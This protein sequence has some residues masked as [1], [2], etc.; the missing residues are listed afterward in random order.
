MRKRIDI[1]PLVL[2]ASLFSCRESQSVDG[3]GNDLTIGSYSLEYVKS[4]GFTG[5]IHVRM[6]V[7]ST[8]DVVL[9][10]ASPTIAGALTASEQSRLATLGSEIWSQPDTLRGGCIDDFHFLIQWTD[11]RGT[12]TISADGCSLTLNNGTDHAAILGLVQILDSIASRVFQEG[13]TWRGMEAFFS[14][15][16]SSYALG[17]PITLKYALTNPTARVRSIFFPHAEQYWFTVSKDN[18]PSFYYTVP[19][20][21][22][23]PDSTPMSSIV[24]APGQEKDLVYAWDQSVIDS[25][26]I[27]GTLGVGSY[28]IQMGL[29]AGDFGAQYAA[30]DVYDASIPIKGRIVP[31][32]AD[33]YSTSSQYTFQL[34]VTNWT[35]TPITLHFPG[36]QKIALEVWDLN[37]DPPTTLL[38][39]SPVVESGP[40]EA[41]T[42]PSHA[43]FSFTE[44]VNKHSMNLLSYWVLAKMHL[45]ASD[46]AFECDGQLA[47]SRFQESSVNQQASVDHE[48]DRP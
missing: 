37:S 4:G 2:A 10:S 14:I 22:S 15:D 6:T 29:L 26:G 32:Y 20:F 36:S 21:A 30:F 19:S 7:S 24:L 43:T 28:R 39:N 40:A 42:L 33:E 12:K 25:K 3:P 13:A 35:S 38:Y 34:E 1:L 44:T 27:P 41:L 18:F 5:G 11:P 45:L 46:F 31:D 16:D 9:T 23:Y 47:I 8:G 17:H 48:R